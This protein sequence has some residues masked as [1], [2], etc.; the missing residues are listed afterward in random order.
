MP[1]GT[2]TRREFL[3]T[4]AAAGATLVIGFYLPA[5]EQRATPTLARSPGPAPFKPNAWI[6]I[7]PDGAVTIWTGRSEMG[8]GVKTAMPMIA[9]EELEADWSRVTVVQADADPAYGDQFTVGSRSVR[10]G[11]EPLRRAGAAAREMLIGAAALTWNVP[12]ETCR[13]QNG[14]VEHLPTGRRLAY[15]ELAAR[16]ATFPVPTDPP[17]KPTSEFRILGHPIP[18]VDTP[19][20]V[21]GTATFGM[22]VRV[23]DM[24]YAAVARCPVFGG[25]VR[26]FD[27]APALAVPGVRRVVEISSGVAVVA[28]GTWA[29]FQGKRALKV[30]WDEGTT[31]EW[32]NDSIWRAF[33][34]A[35]ERPG[36]V[37]RQVGDVDVA[38]AGTART[39]AAVYQ[40]PFLAHACMEPMNCTAQVDHA[41]CEI[42]APTQNPQ[43]V[44]RAAARVTGL[45]LEAVTV[46]VTYLGG[47]FGRRGGPT[48]YATEAAELAQKIGTPVQVVWTRE[49]DI[50]NAVYRPATYNVLRAG[51]DERGAPLAWSHR[52]VGPAGASFLLTRGADELIYPVSHFRLERAT[53]DAGIPIGPWRGVGPSQNGWVVESFVDELAHAAGTD[54]YHYRRGLVSAEPR[55]EQVL[56]LAAERA[57]WGSPAS[58]GRGRGIALWRFGETFLAQVAEVSAGADGR[59]HVHRVVCA[60]DCGIVVNPAGVVAQI[61]GAI[62]YGLT[63][64]LYGEIT[65]DRGRVVQHNFDDYRMLS[66]AETPAIDVHLV[67]SDAPPSGVGEAG[68]PPVAPAVCNAL[69]A[70]TGKRIRRLPIGWVA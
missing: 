53:V 5:L 57:G 34:A 35:A 60:V 44:Q 69:F 24:R 63:A 4:G 40:A 45:P 56:D 16:A 29:A 48:D 62:V 49:D 17:L 37:V 70:A 46:H 58:A 52:L 67:R 32:S 55:L 14:F 19:D 64:A 54:P 9:A 3:H 12:R 22:D 21:S 20:K 10:S 7:T 42:W 39:V 28:D 41:R 61:E 30:E 8:Q 51:L 11:F 36:E 47:G 31:T 38:F 13:A 23:P 68:L 65:I 15:G 1:D 6:Q 25:R 27:P 50:Q 33:A 59:V 18:R 66:L 2:V 43:G 26:S